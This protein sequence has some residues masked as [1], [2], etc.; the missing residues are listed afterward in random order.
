[1]PI[2]VAESPKEGMNAIVQEINV[3]ESI[4]AGRVT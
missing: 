1:V 2:E 3:G 4:T